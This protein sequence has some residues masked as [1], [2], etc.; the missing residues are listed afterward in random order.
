MVRS[1]LLAGTGEDGLTPAPVGSPARSLVDAPEN[2][3][4]VRASAPFGTDELRQG[5]AALPP[6]F[7]PAPYLGATEP[8][9]PRAER[10]IFGEW[11][12]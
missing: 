2:Q 4:Q 5:A 6:P 3:I 12:F 11:T 1:A 8:G 10:W 7:E 9:L